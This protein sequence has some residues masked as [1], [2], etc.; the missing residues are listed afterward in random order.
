[1]ALQFGGTNAFN[2]ACFS[3]QLAMIFASAELD[4]LL[5]KP[6]SNSEKT[7]FVAA[8]QKA[9]SEDWAKCLILLGMQF[10]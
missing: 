8:K 1:M 5:K 9:Q 10:Q 2:I 6:F 3:W 4:H 7:F